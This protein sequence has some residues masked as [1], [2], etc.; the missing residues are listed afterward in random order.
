MI[1]IAEAYAQVQYRLIDAVS[2]A[3]AHVAKPVP[4]CPG[5]SVHDVVAHIVGVV[6]D[7]GAGRLFA[8]ADRLTDQWRDPQVQQARDAM[9]ARQVAARRNV[10]ISELIQEWHRATTVVTPILRGEVAPPPPLPGFTAY[11]LV[12]DLV[13]HEADIRSAL[14]LGRAS[15]TAA[16]SLA[17]AGY[18]SSLEQRIRELGLSDLVLAYDGKQR[19]LGDSGKLGAT[20]T[21]DRYELV[22]VLAG[23]RTGKQILELDWIG[24]PNPFLD[25]LSE[26]GPV[27]TPTVD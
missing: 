5:W 7:V 18:A 12:N 21:A 10:S 9:T 4:A 14:G 20:V 11:I 19:R 27:T 26:Y 1:D 3:G 24:D 2:G 8:G 15:E 17:L 23:R 16:L 25:V 6:V 13:V 22:R